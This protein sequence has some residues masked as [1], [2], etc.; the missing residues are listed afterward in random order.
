MTPSTSPITP[1]TMIPNSVIVPSETLKPANSIG[2]SVPGIAITPEMKTSSV[3]PAYPRSLM[4]CVASVTSPLV[5]EA[6][7]INTVAKRSGR[8]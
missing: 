6:K 5:T 3:I 8:E 7:A 4:M 1:A 2:A